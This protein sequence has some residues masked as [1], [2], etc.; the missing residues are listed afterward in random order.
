MITVISHIFNEEYLLPFWL[1][2]HM[3]IFDHGIIIDYCSTDRS[4][5]IIHKYC[6]TWEVIRTQ[7]L[8]ADGSP[9]FKAHEVDCEVSN[10]ESRIDGYKICLNTTEFMFLTKPKEEIMNI[11][12]TNLYYCLGIHS[13]MNKTQNFFPKNA[14]DFLKGIELIGL[15][16]S[17]RGH[18][19]L[20]SDKR[21]HY[22]TG[23]HNHY[24]NNP[25]NNI[26]NHELFFVLWTKFYPCNNNMFKRKLQI[27]QN[28]PM[29]DKNA[30]LGY[31][32]VTNLQKLYDEYNIDLSTTVSNIQDYIPYVKKGIADACQII[33]KKNIHYSELLVDS[34]YGENYVMLDRDIN[35]LQK[36]DFDNV[37]YKIFDI[38]PVNDL[39]QR[40]I[41]NE[42]YFITKKDILL[43]NY[44]NE[45]T[46]E[47]HTAILNSMPYK[48]NMYTDV[49]KFSDYL[50]K[51]V[52]DILGESVK[53][54]ND[55]L[56][57]RIC[58]P[59]KLNDNDYNPCHRDVYLDFYRNIV[60][61]YLPVVGSNEK[62][63][64]T[65]ASGSHKWSESDTMVTSGG[66]HFKTQNKKYSVDAIVA[67]KMPIEMIRPDPS[68]SQLMLFSPYLI[69][70]C[71]QN[72]NE[73][74]TR[75][76]LEVRFVRNDE[77]GK[78]QEADFN[79]FL[80]KRNWR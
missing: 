70:G 45:I 75:I 8:N 13:V 78:K 17:E 2:H 16:N 33:Q 32:H 76:S 9:N 19:I 51:M 36:T 12:T 60:N 28:I 11:L 18:R 67:S 57:F 6:P 72:N 4:V 21:I 56:W 29:S 31:Q 41:R 20:H 65:V 68:V 34:K 49:K 40:F 25:R 24:T 71:A 77:A 26:Y 55:D 63:S 54:F 73:D 48:K 14:V 7:N 39:M 79:S 35:L 38:Q 50:E 3:N 80:K 30:R 22:T 61:I 43:E 52:S 69:H 53:I 15:A 44:H 5:E 64:L 10:I 1:E 46:N 62:S 23:R 27:Q 47:E 42:I 74:T 58:R 66:A 37:G 59:S